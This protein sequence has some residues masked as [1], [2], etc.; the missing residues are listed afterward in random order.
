[1]K[2]RYF[3]ASRLRRPNF[4]K[5]PRQLQGCTYVSSFLR[6]TQQ[7]NSKEV[8]RFHVNVRGRVFWSAHGERVLLGKGAHAVSGPQHWQ[9]IHILW[10]HIAIY[11]LRVA[12]DSSFRHIQF[13]AHLSR[14]N[15]EWAKPVTDFILQY[16]I[17]I[18]ISHMH[19]LTAIKVN[20]N[21][22]TVG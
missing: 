15:S 2:C 4:W 20:H 5:K 6:R 8:M 10:R 17:S 16:W 9:H 21:G 7:W 11:T 14:A 1:M 13:E 18:E 3:P 19:C 22:S 12:S